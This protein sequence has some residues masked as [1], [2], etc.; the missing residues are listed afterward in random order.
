MNT[1]QRIVE[2]SADQLRDKGFD[3]FS[4]LDISRE[5]G[6]TKASVH[7]HF[8]KKEDLGLAL[9]QWTSD[10]LKQ[11]LDHFDNHASSN[12]NK[13]ERYTRAAV[14]HTLTD[15]K[16]CPVSAFYGDLNKLPD[17]IKGELKRLDEIE[18]NWVA[19]VIDQ[20][21]RDHEF[22]AALDTRSMAALFLFSCKGALYHAR[23]HGQ[24]TLYQAMTQYEKLLK[25]NASAQ[26]FNTQIQY[27]IY[28]FRRLR[29]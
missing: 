18:L 27:S 5:L 28:L 21:K 6:I 25:A 1:K 13:L 17:S 2:F 8:P 14:K 24:E 20:G 10:W 9:C 16:I 15:K 11:G 23:M 26:Q 12:W 4:Y 22:D 29:L 3:G 19:K 7:H